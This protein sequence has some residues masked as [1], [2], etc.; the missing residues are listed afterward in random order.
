MIVGRKDGPPPFLPLSLALFED[1]GNTHAAADAQGGQALLGIGPF[2]HLMEQGDDDAGAGAADRVADG[3]GAAVDIDLLHVEAQLAGHGDGLGGKGLVGLHQIN[4]LD[5]KAR[6]AHGLTAGG[7]G[8]DTHDLGI[9]AA[10]APAH[11]LGHG[12]EAVLLHGLLGG[13]N[14]G[15]RAVVDAAGLARSHPLHMLVGV[16]RVNL[17][18]LK[19]VDNLV[20]HPGYNVTSGI[21]TTGRQQAS[22]VCAAD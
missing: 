1:G 3:D 17:G 6:L 7:H 18:G 4:V 22:L 20:L 19:G 5:L 21:G 8:A 10:V 14:N 12:L 16:I 2:G 13:Q 11:Q 15:G 9:H